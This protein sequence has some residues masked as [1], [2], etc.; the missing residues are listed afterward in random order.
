MAGFARLGP[1]Q[2]GLVALCPHF[3]PSS[4]HSAPAGSGQGSR[5]ALEP[6]RDK[7][8]AGKRRGWGCAHPAPSPAQARPMLLP[9]LSLAGLCH[10]GNPGFNS[11]YHLLP[12][13]WI[14]KYH[15][16]FPSADLLVP[17]PAEARGSL[18]WG[19]FECYWHS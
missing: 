6:G 5:A 13:S 8:Q 15:Q 18:I 14:R 9:R 16:A 19:R 11:G 10:A 3:L 4:A 12:K 17:A 7:S 1:C 2:A